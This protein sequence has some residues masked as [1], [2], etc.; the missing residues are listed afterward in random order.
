VKRREFI[1]LLVGAAAWPLVAR[2]QQP[3]LPVIGFLSSEGAN[4]FA[5]R[6][7]SFRRG[8]SETGYVEGRN[9]AIEYRWAE[10]DNERLPALAADLVRRRLTV[11]AAA[12]GPAAR[13]AKAA[14]TTVPIAFWIE[15]DPVEVGLVASLNQPDSNLT[16]VT[17]LGA[18]LGAK[19]IELLH[20]VI[21]TAS[22]IAALVDPRTLTAG[23]LTSGLQSAARMLGLELHV[24]HASSEADFAA[25]FATLIERRIGGS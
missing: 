17:T 3:A 6:V 25:A 13:S 19:R 9:V 16:G 7:G 18:E 20:D 14:S 23:T 4:Q 22:T 15:G 8:L 24:L 2:A 1:T 21:P 10:G 12:G 11:I 5:D